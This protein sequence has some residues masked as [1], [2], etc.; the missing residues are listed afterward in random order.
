MTMPLEK[1][2][3]FSMLLKLTAFVAFAMCWPIFDFPDKLILKGL[4]F[5][6][7]SLVLW[8][9][10]YD[11]LIMHDL[12]NKMTELESK[13]KSSQDLIAAYEKSLLKKTE[14]EV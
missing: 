8:A 5:V 2:V 11:L 7:F 10:I 13:Q 1:R 12:Q 9:I 4:Y 3:Q 14:K 6:I